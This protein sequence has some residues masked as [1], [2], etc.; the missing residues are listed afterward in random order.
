MSPD[1]QAR[2]ENLETPAEAIDAFYGPPGAPPGD[3]LRAA[4]KL[5]NIRG[6]KPSRPPFVE[7]PSR[8][9]PSKQQGRTETGERPTPGPSTTPTE[10]PRTRTAAPLTEVPPGTSVVLD[11]GE[12][13]V[14]TE[15][16]RLM[17]EVVTESGERVRAVRMSD[18]TIAP[19]KRVREEIALPAGSR[20]RP[21]KKIRDLT[22]E[23]LNDYGAYLETRAMVPLHEHMS[24]DAVDQWTRDMTTLGAV[25]AEIERRYPGLKATRPSG[26]GTLG[27]QIKEG[28]K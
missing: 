27:P 20:G 21:D 11:T 16:N 25:R 4:E 28:C 18:G 10:I 2:Y 23:E 6:P 5:D 8:P 22:D 15:S 12:K 13:G 26:E 9:T 17:R 7:P 14:V 24:R 3:A 1:I 19:E